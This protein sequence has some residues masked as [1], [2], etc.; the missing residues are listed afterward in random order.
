MHVGLCDGIECEFDVNGNMLELGF[1]G[2]P[3]ECG[4]VNV[5]A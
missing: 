5:R 2:N 4:L 1:Q 3:K